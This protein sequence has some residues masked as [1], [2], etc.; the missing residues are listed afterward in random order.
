M[1]PVQVAP[2]AQAKLQPPQLAGSVCTFR[3]Q[4][5]AVLPSQSAKPTLQARSQAPLTEHTDVALAAPGQAEQL[6][7]WQPL[8]GLPIT[9]LPP[10]SLPLGAHGPSG[11]ARSI[12][13]SMLRISAAASREGAPPA[14]AAPPA[15]LAPPAPAAPPVPPAP[16]APPAP[17]VPPGPSSP[18][19]A[20]LR[21]RLPSGSPTPAS[22]RP[23]SSSRPTLRPPVLVEQAKH[24]RHQ[25]PP[26]NNHPGRDMRRPQKLKNSI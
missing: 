6:A 21:P 9:Q 23:P 24:T 5:L 18:P 7:V 8:A 19:P 25:R 17:P 15:P 12:P 26:T 3:S 13:A 11:G 22:P 4:P 16:L 2:L 20:S 14:P 10:H 1:L